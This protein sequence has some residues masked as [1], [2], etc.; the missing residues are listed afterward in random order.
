[1]HTY[2][3]SYKEFVTNVYK[4]YQWAINYPFTHVYGIP[5]GGLVP[6]VMLSHALS[7]PLCTCL[8]S[9]PTGAYV[10]VVDE[11]VDSGKTICAFKQQHCTVSYKYACVYK[12]YTCSE[13]VDFT[14][15]IITHD[16]WLIFPWERLENEDITITT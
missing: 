11:I 9:I 7:L 4:I 5:R 16:A 1:M 3:V 14:A 12:R 10:L 13:H 15:D 8:S 6:A 2:V